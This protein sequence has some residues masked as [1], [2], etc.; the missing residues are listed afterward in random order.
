[1]TSQTPPIN[2]PLTPAQLHKLER[3]IVLFY[4]FRFLREV[5]ADGEDAPVLYEDALTLNELVVA[6]EG[7]G[8]KEVGRH[9]GALQPLCRT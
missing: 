5:R 7:G 2:A 6:D 8:S 1:M 3:N 4:A 9:G